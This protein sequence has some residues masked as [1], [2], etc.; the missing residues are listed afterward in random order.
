MCSLTQQEQALAQ[1]QGGLP[2]LPPGGGVRAGGGGGG[3]GGGE[4]GGGVEGHPVDILQMLAN[5]RNEYDKVGTSATLHSGSFTFCYNYSF[6]PA[7]V[8]KRT[9]GK[10]VGCDALTSPPANCSNRS[11]VHFGAL[12]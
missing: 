1:T 6:L 10:V 4:V 7:R 5:A 2:P 8:D 3:G 9:N 11:A 12:M